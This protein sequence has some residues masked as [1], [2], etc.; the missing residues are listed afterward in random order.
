MRRLAWSVFVTMEDNVT[1]VGKLVSGYGFYGRVP[2]YDFRGLYQLV[3]HTFIYPLLILYGYLTFIPYLLR[4]CYYGAEVLDEDIFNICVGTS[5]VLLGSM[6]GDHFTFKMPEQ[7]PE[8]ITIQWCHLSS[9][10][11]EFT[12]R[13]ITKVVTR[14]VEVNVP[15]RNEVLLA[16]LRCIAA[17][18]VHPTIHLHAEMSALEIQAKN[19]ELLEPSSHFV[20]SLHKGLLHGWFSP[21]SSYSPAYCGTVTPAVAI[22]NFYAFPKPPH[23]IQGDKS[24]FALYHF[25]NAARVEVFRLVAQH[26]LPVDPENLFLNVV[27]H[28]VDHEGLYAAMGGAPLTSMDGSGSIFSYMKTHFF[29][30]VWLRHVNNPLNSD[31]LESHLTNPFYFDLHSALVKIDKGLARHVLMS[32]CF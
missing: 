18:W 32:C 29:T 14:G 11:I 3:T 30:H 26:Q 5:L 22:P 31:R 25:A 16:A 12:N 6:D 17:D 27:M 9:L 24:M 15:K 8:F 7:C 10:E 28:A 1:E 21:L 19:V 20:S 2:G 13:S 23:I 4:S